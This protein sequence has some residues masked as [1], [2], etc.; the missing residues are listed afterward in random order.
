[1][2]FEGL[3]QFMFWSIPFASLINKLA[4]K[5]QAISGTVLQTKSVTSHVNALSE[6]DL[7]LTVQ[8]DIELH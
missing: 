3:M 2:T 1:M 6:W 8:T 4:K 5:K 7:I